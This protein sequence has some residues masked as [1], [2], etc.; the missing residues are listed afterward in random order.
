MRSREP[1][2]Y[3]PIMLGDLTNAPRFSFT[4]GGQTIHHRDV[5]PIQVPSKNALKRSR[6]DK[7]D[8]PLPN[9]VNTF[10]RIAQ[11]PNLEAAVWTHLPLTIVECDD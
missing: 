9:F 5:V 1:R 2:Q 4:F 11:Y 6:N 8:G 7:D 10:D 3:Q